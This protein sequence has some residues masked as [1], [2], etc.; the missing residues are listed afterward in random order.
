[1][2]LILVPAFAIFRPFSVRFNLTA[3]VLLILLGQITALTLVWVPTM[4][5]SSLAGSLAVAAAVMCGVGIYLLLA[6]AVWND[7]GARLIA[8][9]LERL[10]DGDLTVQTSTPMHQQAARSEAGRIW[11]SIAL[12]QRNLVEIVGQVRAA[13]DRVTH[14]S[15]EIASG[16]ADLSQRTEEQASTLEETSA[17]MEELSATVRQNAEH[18]HQANT[19]ADDNAHRAEEAGSSMTSVTATMARIESGSKKMAEII[20]LI[21]GIAFQTNILALNAAV[22]AAR[23]GEQGRGFTVVAAEVRSLAQRTSQAADEIKTL[24]VASTQD[25]GEGAGLATKAQE[26]VNRAVTGMHEISELINAV[27][28]ASEEQSSGVQEVGRAVTQLESMT[29]QNAALVEE[30]A[31]TSTAFEQESSR[32]LDLVGAFKLD[33]MEDRDRAVALVKRAV[34]HMRAHGMTRAFADFCDPNGPFVEGELYIYAYGLDG[35]LS[36]TSNPSSKDNI[37]ENHTRLRDLQGKRYMS[38]M[39]TTAREKGKGWCDYVMQHPKT[40]Q[41]LAKSSYFE[42]VDEYLLGCGIYRPDI[43]I[44]SNVSPSKPDALKGRSVGEQTSYARGTD[45]AKRSA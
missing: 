43:Q 27:A 23:A 26:A 39:I 6:L 3:I 33:R 34:A 36:A 44:R 4:V 37:G 24:I 5:D 21:E 19:R 2:K 32:L 40:N 25:I 35:V 1:M 20:A 8:R 16:Y 41:P 9:V 22:E 15:H 11:A 28:Q 30:G 10:A 42:R 38:E 18:C 14:G 29:Q 12:L 45:A 17:T 7:A 31:A 13:A